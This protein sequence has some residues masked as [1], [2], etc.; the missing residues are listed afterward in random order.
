MI[1]YFS[2]TGNC[3]YVAEKIAKALSDKAFSIEDV[4][5]SLGLAP[6]ESLGIVTPTNW[7]ELPILIRE[8]LEKLTIEGEHYIF[9][10]AT[11]GTT[12]GCCGE[13][14]RRVLKKRGIILNASFSVKMPDNWTPIFDLSDPKKVAEQN[15]AAEESIEKLIPRIHRKEQGN[16]TERRAPYFVRL[17]TDPLLNS[18]RRTKNFYVEDTCIGCGLCARRCPVQAIEIKNKKP[19]WVKDQCALCL[20]CLHHCPKFAI[21]YG[22]GKTKKHGQYL[23]PHVKV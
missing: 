2:A 21:Q 8:F 11:Y 9:L 19:V 10:I 7:W 12:P 4:P 18:E 16:H 1:L 6:E 14:A 23:N 15:E 22:N 5:P 13:D 17:F 3:K 20:R